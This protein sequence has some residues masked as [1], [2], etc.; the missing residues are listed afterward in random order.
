MAR[1]K[2]SEF[3]PEAYR[4]RFLESRDITF[5][6]GDSVS[7]EEIWDYLVNEAPEEYPA[8]FDQDAFHGHQLSGDLTLP[9]AI[10]N[11]YLNLTLSDRLE[12]A[13]DSGAIVALRQGGQAI[14]PYTAAGAL[15]LR[16]FVLGRWAQGRSKGKSYYKSILENKAAKEQAFKDMSFEACQTSGYEYIQEG[17]LRCD[18][19]A[20]YSALRCSDIPYSTEAHR[21]GKRAEE[22]A[23]FV[24]DYPVHRQSD[25]E[26]AIRYFAEN[27]RLLVKELDA[28]SGRATSDEDLRDAIKL[29][30][31][32]RRL[33]IEIAD[34]WW[35]AEQPPTNGTDRSQLFTMGAL[36]IHA[37]VQA[38]LSVLEEARDSIAA[39]VRKG[40]SGYGISKNPKRIFVCGSCV[41]PNSYRVESEGAIL[42]GSDDGWSYNSVLVEEDGD[43]YYNLA[44]ADLSWPYEQ[45]IE[46]RGAW[47]VEQIKRS[48]ADGVLYLY[49]W[50]CN[51][52]SAVSRPIADYVKK[53]TGLPSLI[54]EHE[55]AGVQPEQEHSRISAFIEMVAN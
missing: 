15:S 8:Q 19:V 32:G 30:N 1:N 40:V 3:F 29:H 55:L 17:D 37:D 23:R 2:G 49:N 33:S 34:L 31:R 6:N 22:V 5:T 13:K 7:P 51:T 52:Q 27:L 46:G 20:S 45:S 21:H 36:E 39:R 18:I 54:Y 42:V 35:G 26:W 43:P 16:P 48:R 14:E 44:K 28:L 38:T 41:T 4:D 50:G 53:A 12:K 9:A 11:I 47:I 10:K 25:K 24:V